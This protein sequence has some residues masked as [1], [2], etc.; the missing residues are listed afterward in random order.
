MAI[1]NVGN[2]NATGCTATYYDAKGVGTTENLPSF[3]PF[4]K[5]NTNA[6]QADALSNGD[7][8]TNKTNA[9]VGGALEV[10]CNQPVIVVVRVTKSVSL[11]A[12]TKFGEDYG[13]SSTQ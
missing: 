2:A 13:S 6:A 4:I 11:G 5:V 10:D 9:G 7:F 12:T 8:G 1:M 3:A